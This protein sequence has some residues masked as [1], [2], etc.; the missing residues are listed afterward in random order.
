MEECSPD[1]I[2]FK[3]KVRPF[4]FLVERGAVFSNSLK[5]EIKIRQSE[6]ILI[7]FVTIKGFFNNCN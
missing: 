2:F 5:L 7:V 4:V 6:S 1:L 3:I